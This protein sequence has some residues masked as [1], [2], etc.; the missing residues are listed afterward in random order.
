MLQPCFLFMK[1]KKFSTFFFFG[2]LTSPPQ[3][4]TGLSD[5]AGAPH[6]SGPQGCVFLRPQRRAPRDRDF[7]GRG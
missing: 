3:N 6:R 2:L 7:E 1:K 4:P 5:A